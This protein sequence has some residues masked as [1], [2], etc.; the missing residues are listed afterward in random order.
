[1]ELSRLTAAVAERGGIVAADG[2]GNG[3]EA[4]ASVACQ[5]GGVCDFGEG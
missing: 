3:V 1:V 2:G 5:S 4:E